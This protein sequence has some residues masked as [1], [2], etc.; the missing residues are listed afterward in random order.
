MGSTLLRFDPAVDIL[1]SSSGTVRFVMPGGEFTLR[2]PSGFVKNI[3]RRFEVG[4]SWEVILGEFEDE[5]ER[6]GAAQLLNILTSRR[7][8]TSCEFTP[9]GQD[10][11]RRWVSYYADITDQHAHTICLK[12]EGR[13]IEQLRAR[14][15]GLGISVATDET[16]A[17][18]VIAVSDRPNLAWLR[19]VNRDTAST[20]TSFLPVWLDRSSVRFGPIHMPEATGCLE[21]LLHREQAVRRRCEPV[22][23]EACEVMSVSASV[24]DLA[25]GLVIPEILRWLDDAHVDTDFGFAWRFDTLTM[26]MAVERVVR[27]PNCPVCSPV[28]KGSWNVAAQ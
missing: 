3:C 2:D 14:L 16:L 4:E 19:Q 25:C 17:T 1:H 15:D 5:R 13:L 26:D 11:L 24:V 12:G 18:Q 28:F 9:Q 7:V 21:C 23:D 20:N 6:K 8:L 27:L 10:P 22:V